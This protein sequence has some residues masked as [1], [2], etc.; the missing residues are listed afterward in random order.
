[1]Q[2][3]GFADCLARAGKQFRRLLPAASGVVHAIPRVVAGL[4][5]TAVVLAS[6]GPEFEGLA[7]T[8]AEPARP[9]LS[10]EEPQLPG[11]ESSPAG[12]RSPAAGRQPV[13]ASR[14][15]KVPAG[16]RRIEV[17]RLG[18]VTAHPSGWELVE[19]DHQDRLFTFRLPGDHPG[20]RRALV[21][22]EIGFAPAALE[23]YQ[24]RI[25]SQAEQRRGPGQLLTSEILTENH[26]GRDIRVLEVSWGLKAPEGGMWYLDRRYVIR[27]GFL[28]TWSLR[29]DQ[30]HHEAYLHDLRQMNACTQYME[31]STG[32]EQQPNGL[33]RQ[34]KLGFALRLPKAW[35]PSFQPGRGVALMATG[36]VS[37]VFTENL[38]VSVTP[39]GKIPFEQLQKDLPEQIPQLR[40][41]ARVLHCRTIGEGEN[42]QL[43]TVIELQQG[44]F[45]FVV[46]ERRIPG[47]RQNYILRFTLLQQ[48]Y[49]ALEPGM[50]R[51]F[52]SLREVPPE[53][54]PDDVI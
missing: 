51:S 7:A 1:M 17:L 39:A 5:L 8:G 4:L 31:V 54:G 48:R 15:L 41:G 29:V 45:R 11:A 33:W 47:T 2:R 49:E 50:K 26:D 10:S 53:L 37:E 18:V 38:T 12:E 16:F 42:R 25:R 40:A 20:Q 3:S 36:G 21:M 6:G 23:E 28:Y 44:E 43:E 35:L 52:D 24:R 14:P 19:R 13:R 32:V 27:N 9:A 34:R 46:V 30:G 22:G